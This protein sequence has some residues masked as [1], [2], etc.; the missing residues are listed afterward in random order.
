MQNPARLRL[1]PPFA[2]VLR[3]KIRKRI[4]FTKLPTNCTSEES[5]IPA[6]YDKKY[7]LSD[8]PFKK[9]LGAGKARNKRRFFY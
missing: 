2:G 7:N 3:E 4:R 5:L 9:V 1:L 8:F 6:V